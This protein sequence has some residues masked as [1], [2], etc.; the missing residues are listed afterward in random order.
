M[1]LLYFVLLVCINNTLSYVYSY[2]LPLASGRGA[3]ALSVRKPLEMI[4]SSDSNI[5]EDEMYLLL[6]TKGTS[7]FE[8]A[9]PRRLTLE[10]VQLWEK[11]VDGVASDIT[12]ISDNTLLL[13]LYSTILK[14]VSVKLLD[15]L[16]VASFEIMSGAIVDSL[17]R[18]VGLV[19]ITELVDEIT[20]VHLNYIDDVFRDGVAGATDQEEALVYQFAGLARRTYDRIARGMGAQYDQSSSTLELRL[21]NWVSPV[22]ARLQRRFVR[23]LASNVEEK[24][25]ELNAA[26]VD[27]LLERLMD[28]SLPILIRRMC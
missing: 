25:E 15:P 17:L 22:Y 12:K 21:N 20:Q 23:F 3:S 14:K 16:E 10:A 13:E 7:A 19:P 6:A 11:E 2:K 9:V 4:G 26:S 5:L 24:V 1:S 28:T 8:A 18:N 27:L